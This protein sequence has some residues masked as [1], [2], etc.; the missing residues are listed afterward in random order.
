MAKYDDVD[1]IITD[2]EVETHVI[3]CWVVLLPNS[4]SKY[5][6]CS[7]LAYRLLQ[8][9]S[10]RQHLDWELIAVLKQT[11]LVKSNLK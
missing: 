8:L 10:K 6:T 1:D 7:A 4:Q 9:Y 11:V 5:F 3:L 2:E